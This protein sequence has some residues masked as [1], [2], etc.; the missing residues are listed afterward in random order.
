[1]D[2]R[3]SPAAAHP[4]EPGTD[5]DELLH[6]AL[7]ASRRNQIHAALGYLDRAL[8]LTPADARLYLLQGALHAGRGATEPALAAMERAVALGP[9]LWGAHFQLGL[10]YSTNGRVDEAMRAWAPLDALAKGH[11]LRSFKTGLE[12]LERADDDACL[13]HLQAGI[14]AN[15]ESEALNGDMRRVIEKVR[16]RRQGG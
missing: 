16:A 3:R 2:A 6:L 15:S 9:K 14:D 13:A 12:A 7:R 10:L 5:A 1:M 4:D 8:K 11:P